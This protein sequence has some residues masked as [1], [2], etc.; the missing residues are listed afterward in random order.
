MQCICEAY[1]I[2]TEK[3]SDVKKYEIKPTLEVSNYCTCVP[4]ATGYVYVCST[5]VVLVKGLHSL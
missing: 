5:V 2:S 4:A 3:E 1:G